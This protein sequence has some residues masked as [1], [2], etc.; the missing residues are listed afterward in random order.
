METKLGL[1][2]NW[3]QFTILVIVNGFVGAHIP[4]IGVS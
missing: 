1:R 2:E 3:K 4:E